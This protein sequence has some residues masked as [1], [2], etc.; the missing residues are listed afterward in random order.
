[1]DILAQT[2]VEIREAERRYRARKEADDRLRRPIVVIDRMLQELEELN[3]RGYKRV[4]LAY[5]ER[6]HSLVTMVAG[7]S[8]CGAALENL[9]VKIGIPKLMD[10]LFAVQAA[11]FTQRTGGVYPPDDDL[12]FAA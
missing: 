6:L 2:N 12:I 4:P 1:M 7:V 9:K 10:A 3:L 11:L 8:N 5:E